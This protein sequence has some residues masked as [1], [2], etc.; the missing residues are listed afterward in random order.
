MNGGSNDRCLMWSAAWPPG[1]C[2]DGFQVNG[3]N[4]ASDTTQVWG[5]GIGGLNKSF[6]FADFPAGLSRT[7]AVEEI[8]AGT[9][10]LDR[11]GVWTLGFPGSSVTV[12]HGLNGNRGPNAGK[13]FI[14]GCGAAKAARGLV[15]PPCRSILRLDISEQSDTCAARTQTASICS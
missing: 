3:T 5:S 14:Q 12:A 2:T 10:P 13:D 1:T 6:R 4:L 8:R 9:H 15:D 11:R 7:V